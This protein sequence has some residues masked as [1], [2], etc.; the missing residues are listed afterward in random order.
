[1]RILPPLL[2]WMNVSAAAAT[3][4]SG[5]AASCAMSASLALLVGWAV[6]ILQFAQLPSF[7]S[8]HGRLYVGRIS[9]LLLSVGGRGVGA[10]TDDDDDDGCPHICKES[11]SARLL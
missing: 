3:T 10:A 11:V 2:K 7:L 8:S 4:A 1:M 5:G 9:F 6:I